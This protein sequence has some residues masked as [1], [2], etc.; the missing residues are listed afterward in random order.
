MGHPR[1]VWATRQAD[2]EVAIYPS[3][4]GETRIGGESGAVGVEQ[5][6]VVCIRREGTGAGEFSGVD[7]E[8]QDDETRGIWED[9]GRIVL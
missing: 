3:K 4:P 2:G 5:F 1:V 9:V 6:P 7:G 8:D